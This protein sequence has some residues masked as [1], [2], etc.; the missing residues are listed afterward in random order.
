MQPQ[1]RVIL[2]S[3]VPGPLS[4]ISRLTLR[5]ASLTSAINRGIR[6]TKG[7]VDKLER[8]APSRY[9]QGSDPA[10]TVPPR[11]RPWREEG[12]ADN[13]DKRSPSRY[14]QR[15][16]G[17]EPA[18]PRSRPW[19]DDR[20]PEM[21]DSSGREDW[22]THGSQAS[23]SDRESTFSAPIRRGEVNPADSP[24]VP[25]NRAERRLVQFGRA[26]D[27]EGDVADQQRIP[28]PEV[29]NR[30]RANLEGP[31]RPRYEQHPRD[32]PDSRRHMENSEGLY[33]PK[34]AAYKGSA[35][36]TRPS[37]ARAG[38]DDAE[39]A[40]E[41]YRAGNVSERLSHRRESRLAKNRRQELRDDIKAIGDPVER[42]WKRQS[43]MK[44]PLSVPYTT[45]G[46]EFLYGTH[47]VKAA[48]QAGRRQ[49]HKL[50]L[51][52]TDD[53]RMPHNVIP[54]KQTIH[55]LALAAGVEVVKVSRD[56]ETLLMK[57][58]NQRP[59]N[60][61]VLE[62]SPI[63]RLPAMKLEE[64][65]KTASRFEITTTFQSGEV[66]V[67]NSTFDMD[68]KARTAYI[69][70]VGAGKRFPFV[71]LLDGITDSGNLGAIIRSA[72]FLGIDAVILL[73]HGTA[74][75]GPLALK[76]SAG[77]GEHLPLLIIKNVV[78][79]IKASQKNGWKFF[80]AV[81]PDSAVKPDPGR[82]SI[83]E[84]GKKNKAPLAFMDPA[85]FVAEHPTVLILGSEGEG[86]RP[87]LEKLSDGAVG[88]ENARGAENKVVDSLN[89]SVAAALLMR[90]FL[91]D[92]ETSGKR[93]VPADDVF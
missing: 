31:F 64:V 52:S 74:T 5:H 55:K 6:R 29:D 63:P 12:G 8:R 2:L 26:K 51:A 36:R 76:A 77:A 33:T 92:R 16:E 47:G 9:S 61:Y 25:K 28:R 78:A 15:R 73:E 44:V 79:F 68:L 59:H 38:D 70:T 62:A 39:E 1:L 56:W 17:P 3:R 40:E 45:A 27:R 35:G 7:G 32:E 53:Q 50:Y 90:D 91:R 72:Y 65:S 82:L 81:S 54:E 20:R 75:L 10:E 86:I 57:M 58:S 46:S 4:A 19:R 89:V 22:R 83:S 84:T 60:G 37:S 48:L 67:V 11:A 88:L 14:N 42:E 93:V 87:W 85:G 41:K 18:S 24:F 21:R 49:L 34:R 66:R 80:A 13:L 71:L 23:T 69:P 30:A 43:T